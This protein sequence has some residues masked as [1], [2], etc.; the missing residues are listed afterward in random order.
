M[1]LHPFKPPPEDLTHGTPIE[2]PQCCAP[3]TFDRDTPEGAEV[4]P[5]ACW[6][7]PH[8]GMWECTE[9]MYK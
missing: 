6:W 8:T 3:A 5:G 4:K 2:C 7:N 1:T 9:C